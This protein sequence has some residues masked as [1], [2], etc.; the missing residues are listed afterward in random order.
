MRSAR[1]RGQRSLGYYL[2]IVCPLGVQN[3]DDPHRAVERRVENDLMEE[4]R[5]NL[6]H[7]YLRT[8]EYQPNASRR[9][10]ALI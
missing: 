10:A 6:L 5:E 3:L 9:N 4:L 2:A 7:L 1:V 8:K